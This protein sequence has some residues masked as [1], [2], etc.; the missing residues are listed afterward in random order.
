MLPYIDD[1]FLEMIPRRF[2]M[3]TKTKRKKGL[4]CVFSNT[5]L[6]YNSIN[7]IFEMIPQKIENRNQNE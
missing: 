6:Q 4:F 5:F 7:L 1:F 3:V 2:E